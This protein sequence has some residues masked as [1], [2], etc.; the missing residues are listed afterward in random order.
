MLHVNKLVLKKYDK[1]G[2]N[3]RIEYLYDN[4]YWVFIKE[5]YGTVNVKF[6][7]CKGVGLVADIY[8]DQIFFMKDSYDPETISLEGIDQYIKNANTI[9]DLAIYVRDHL[10][11]LCNG[12][13][14]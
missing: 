9:R 2:E 12:I 8:K 7:C 1:K 13:I 14:E 5:I 3:K 4:T 6:N 11:P 10:N